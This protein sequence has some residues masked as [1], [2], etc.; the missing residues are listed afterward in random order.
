MRALFS[1]LALAAYTG[2]ASGA[3]PPAQP[4]APELPRGQILDRVEIRSDPSLSYALYIPS[5]FR[6]DRQWPILYAFNVRAGGRL[7][8]ERFRA[9]AEKYGFLIASSN[10]TTSDGPTLEPN[11]QATRAMWADTHE[12]FPIDDKRVYAAGFS[13]TARFA[14]FLAFASPGSIAGVIASGAGFPAGRKPAPDTPFL[15]FGTIGDRDFNYYEVLDLDEELTGLGLPHRV[16]LF[17]GTHEWMPERLATK[18]LGWMELQAM[19]AGTRAKD[20]ALVEALWSADLEQAKA[21]E[22]SD[23]VEAHRLYAEMVQDFRGLLD[24]ETLNSVAVK[25]SEIAASVAFK[26][27]SKL[28]QQRDQRDKDYIARAPKALSTTDMTQAI[29]AL[30]I[31]ELKRTAESSNQQES[32]AA[33]RLLN[34]VL[35]QTTFYLP[36]MYTEQGNHDRAIFVLSI[37]TEIVP[38]RPEIWYELA[39]AQARKGAKKKALDHLRKAVEKGWRDLPRLEAE[40]AFAP[41][42]QDKGYREMVEEVRK[43]PA[44]A[45]PG[46]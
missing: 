41:M 2:L 24:P 35:I 12:R 34:T 4:Q 25:V 38:D 21:L 1:L 32:L 46:S 43:M 19:K 20:P 3:E 5:S 45:A 30:R 42:R 44:A 18:A 8:A 6:P 28:R 27:E 26:K 29:E 16:E 7:P 31:Y 9:G 17:P 13:G 14:G 11:V 23:V 33:K 36:R 15:Y 37:A 22:P 39:A 10:D 40:A